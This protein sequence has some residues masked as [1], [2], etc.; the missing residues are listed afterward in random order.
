MIVTRRNQYLG[1]NAHTNS[2]ILD[3]EGEW[4]SFHARHIV[5]IAQKLDEVLPQGY[6]ARPERSLQV[7]IIY[8]RQNDQPE[9]DVPQKERFYPQPDVS[10]Y[11]VGP[12]G[13][14]QSGTPRINVPTFEASVIWVSLST[15]RA[16]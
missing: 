10:I 2:W 11:N 15:S 4:G 6:E 8:H 3:R 12:I 7:E 13:K 5:D 9:S 16:P 14:M 1:I